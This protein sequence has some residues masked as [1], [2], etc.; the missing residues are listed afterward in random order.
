MGVSTKCANICFQKTGPV[1]PSWRAPAHPLFSDRPMPRRAALFH[2]RCRAP[3]FLFSLLALAIAGSAAWGADATSPEVWET[4]A[5]AADEIEAE[6][7]ELRDELIAAHLGYLAALKAAAAELEDMTEDDPR[8]PLAWARVE[9]LMETSFRLLE[10]TGEHE[11]FLAATV[12]LRPKPMPAPDAVL[13]EPAANGA[14]AEEEAPD[15]GL[16][17]VGADGRR[18]LPVWR[19]GYPVLLDSR[20]D[21]PASPMETVIARPAKKETPKGG[22]V[23]VPLIRARAA[24]LRAAILERLGRTSEAEQEVAGLGLVRDWLLLGPLDS[25]AAAS[26]FT[27]ND[28]DEVY[29]NLDPAAEYPGKNGPVRWRPFHSVDALGRLFP[30]ALFRSSGSRMVCALALVHSPVNGEAVLRLGS[31]ASSSAAVNH[32]VVRRERSGGQTAPDRAA[33]SVWLRKGWN[34]LVIRTDSASENWTLAVRLT[35]P[36]GTPFP[37]QTVGITGENVAAVLAQ[38]ELTARR[39]VLDRHYQPGNLPDMG[40]VSV[41]SRRTSQVSGDARA[42][43]YLASLLV[44]RRM[45]EGDERFDRELLFRRAIDASGNNPFFS[46]MAARSVDFGVE[47]PDREENLRL[48][49]LRSAADQGSAAALADMGRLYLD[50]MRQPR[51][52]GGYAEQALEVNPMSLRAGI[53]GYDVAVRMGWLPLAETQLKRL[54]ARHPSSSAARLRLGRAALAGGRPR[55]ALT[56]FHAILGTDAGNR[57][58][59]NGAIEALGMLGQN[60]AAV[61]LLLRRIE[62]S[63]YDY[64]VR[65]KLAELYRILGRETEAMNTTRNALVMAPDDAEARA[66]LDD[67]NRKSHSVNRSPVVADTRGRLPEEVDFSPPATP[68]PNGWEYLYLQ[69]ADRMDGGGGIDRVVSFALKIHSERAAFSIRHI[70]FPLGLDFESG[71]VTMLELVH[72]DGAREILTVDA[73][74][75]T[76]GSLT[77]LLPPLRQGMTI[78]A[79]V[80]IRRERVPFLGEYFGQIAS[81]VQSAPTRL[82]RYMFTAP[83]ERRIFFRPING[84]PEAM[85]IESSDGREI[86]RIWEMSDLPAFIPE[87]DSPGPQKNAPGIEMS[88]FNDWNEFA[89]WYWRL[90][91]GQYQAPPELLRLA[92]AA[93]DGG[94]VPMARLDSAAEWVAENIVH[95]EWEYGPYAFRPINAR[96]ILSRLS[97]DSK[98]RTLL[99]CLLARQ[100]GLEAWP[101]LARFRGRQY[102]ATGSGELSLP[103]L[104]HFNHSLAAVKSDGGDVFFDASNPFRP[105]GVMPSQ[106]FGAAAMVITPNAADEALIPDGGVSACSWEES[107]ELVV[108]EDG[109]L[110]WE[111]EIRASGTA[112]EALRFRFHNPDAVGDPWSAFL[113][114]LGAVPS[115]AWNEF[116]DDPVGPAAASFAGRAR[117]KQLAVLD[118]RHAI[119]R[120]PALPGLTTHGGGAFAYPLSLDGYANQGVR[121]QDLELPHGFRVTRRLAIVYPEEWRLVNP[122]E[123]FS[124]RFEFGEVSMTSEFIPGRLT[125]TFTVEIPGHRLTAA[126]FRDFREMAALVRRWMR[127]LLV[128]EKP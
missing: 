105:P 104:D 11:T 12:A 124:K 64:G 18:L 26:P 24:W 92:E 39:S 8:F 114:S 81:L 116:K 57:E 113:S 19:D 25:D 121:E 118:D 43:F 58:A 85:V 50:V 44:A 10:D 16:E 48:V 33:A 70:G 90:I 115:A 112:A 62:R 46:L 119:L 127:P 2:A 102:A 69:V 28:V 37:G 4:F 109:S 17:Y 68:P 40:G 88:S 106:L 98:D 27:A 73:A 29:R 30:G 23:F 41:L 86:T 99:L 63:P 67:I 59:L 78:V 76:T 21:T 87:P 89:R 52:A 128:W 110:L 107:A 122:G 84:A 54:V 82:S 93:A 75:P 77:F 47:G 14:G 56:E 80:V 108:D 120:V 126:S 125:I 95:R 53:L 96:S 36:D 74:K 111:E 100:Y 32:Q 13:L 51:R 20:T 7:L 79:E 1:A 60:S 94:D 72:S 38:A 6:R 42:N 22:A 103:L 45:M 97:A 9:Y 65:L 123:S 31:N 101:V 49:L 61:D 15:G 55:L 3:F 66:M 117:L 71:R 5:G 83:R 35:A 91:G 34:V